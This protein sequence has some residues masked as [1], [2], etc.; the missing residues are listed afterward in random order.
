MGEAK[1]KGSGNSG[2]WAGSSYQT[3][4]LLPAAVS[5][6]PANQVYRECGE[7]CGKTCSNPQH[8]C[9]SFCTFGCFCPHGEDV[10]QHPLSPKL[11]RTLTQLGLDILYLSPGSRPYLPTPK[12]PVNPGLHAE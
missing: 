2:R 11:T 12:L 8:S 3:L 6:C 4:C 10:Y 1:Q 9:S 5:Q 7:V